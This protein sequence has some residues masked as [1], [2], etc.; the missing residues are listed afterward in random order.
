M[1]DKI[2]EN[3]IKDMSNTII[4]TNYIKPNNR[5]Q[6]I[7]CNKKIRISNLE[8]R[9]GK[10]FCSHHTFPEDHKCD[11]DYKDPLK[12]EKSIEEMKCKSNKIQKI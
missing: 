9:C 10:T 12:R 8:C 2:I 7:S 5:C 1:K 11:Y 3:K 4:D 6:F